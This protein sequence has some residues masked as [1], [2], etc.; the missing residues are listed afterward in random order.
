M[1]NTQSEWDNKLCSKLVDEEI[2][3]P[4]NGFD[5]IYNKVHDTAI[6]KVPWFKLIIDGSLALSICGYLLVSA[7]S[8]Y[9]QLADRNLGRMNTTQPEDKKNVVHPNYD[10]SRNNINESGKY[11]LKDEV[12]SDDIF[13]TCT[14]VNVDVGVASKVNHVKSDKPN[15]HELFNTTHKP[16]NVSSNKPKFSNEEV[17]NIKSESSLAYLDYLPSINVRLKTAAFISHP[18]NRPY[19]KYV[20]M[21]TPKAYSRFSI[22]AGVGNVNFKKQYSAADAKLNLIRANSE[23]LKQGYQLKLAVGYRINSKFLLKTGIRFIHQKEVMKYKY[24]ASKYVKTTYDTTITGYI[25]QP[26]QPPIPKYNLTPIHHYNAQEKHFYF[27]NSYDLLQLELG[28][29]T[30][31]WQ[32]GRWSVAGTLMYDINVFSKQEGKVFANRNF[33]TIDLVKNSARNFLKQNNAVAGIQGKFQIKEK[34]SL[35]IETEFI[36]GTRAIGIGN[37]IRPQKAVGYT[38]VVGMMVQL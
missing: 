6:T 30:T 17:E 29:S 18:L 3:L 10:A 20:S 13:E 33:E 8:N 32:Y 24:N 16:I 19:K 11:H 2:M 5:A 35:M 38:T 34:V 1:K 23:T 7:Y 12:K 22:H 31:L 9:C 4:S 21:P 15:K 36:G 14:S 37:T 27:D 26:F 25:L 28:V